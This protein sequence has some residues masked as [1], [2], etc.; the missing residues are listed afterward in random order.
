MLHD[1]QELGRRNVL[2][3]VARVASLDYQLRECLAGTADQYVLLDE[4]VETA[5]A[6]AE[7]AASHPVLSRK[8]NAE[9]QKALLEFVR[10]ASTLFDQM[11]WQDSKVSLGEIIH[12]HSMQRIREA[13][14]ECLHRV[15]ASFTLE[16]LLRD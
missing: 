2:R 9:Q 14:D 12:S 4:L 7:Q 5:I 11:K 6:R 13:A 10:K 15:G 16:E 3:D 8:W 1:D